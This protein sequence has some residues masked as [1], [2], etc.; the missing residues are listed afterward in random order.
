MFRPRRLRPLLGLVC[1]GLV[2]GLIASP[3][4]ATFPGG[5]GR[6]AY[7]WSLGGEGFEEGPSPR[8]VGVVSVRPDG[9]GRQLV[10]R[11]GTRPRYSPDGRRIAFL[12]SHHPWV[13]RADGRSA[14][15]VS[16]SDWLVGSYD[17]SPRGTRLAFVRDFVNGG[18]A[19]YTVRPDGSGLQ[20]L[21]KASQGI[22]LAPGAWS[23][24]GKAI[25][26]E[27]HSLRTLVRVSRAGRITTLARVSHR[28]TWSRRGLIAYDTL[29]F[30]QYNQVCVRQLEAV[31]PLRC[32]GFAD[33]AV[34]DPT[35]SPDG[36]RL[37]FMYTPQ[38]QGPAE[39]W[40]VRPDG[41]VLTRA[42]RD[43][44]FPIFSPDG[45]RLAFSETR[46][47]SGLAFQDLHVMR[48]DGSGKRRLVRGGQASG[49][50]WR[51]LR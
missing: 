5:N 29:L 44:S 19:I 38:L 1:L 31:A 2:A 9:G 48:P 40:T 4:Q 35:W 22:T 3:A 16:P 33:A 41:T 10:A 12:R 47:R 6:I 42:P 25:V 32:F 11:R 27:Q 21:V 15:Q 13:A 20:R 45:R 30:G 51:P 46:I 7:T 18:A 26:Y 34:S 8:L 36:R 37:M 49:A 17:W 14:R 28:P 39:L 23:P 24:D 43:N 50:D